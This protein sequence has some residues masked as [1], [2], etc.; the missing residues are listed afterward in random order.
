MDLARSGGHNIFPFTYAGEGKD[1][2][3]EVKLLDG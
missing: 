2:K 1:E 3:F